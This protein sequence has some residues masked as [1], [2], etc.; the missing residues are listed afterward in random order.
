M[1]NVI[2]TVPNILKYNDALSYMRRSIIVNNLSSTIYVS[3]SVVSTD[4]FPTLP[5][6]HLSVTAGSDDG[7]SKTEH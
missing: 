7:N 3:F 1:Q 2:I 6:G 4:G 5:F